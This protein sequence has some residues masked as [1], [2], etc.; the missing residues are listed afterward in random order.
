MFLLNKLKIMYSVYLLFWNER[1]IYL[2]KEWTHRQCFNEDF[3]L[4]S[5]IPKKDTCK[6]SSD[7]GKEELKVIHAL[8]LRKAEAS[9]EGLRN[10]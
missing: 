2:I 7:H 8:H 6:I 9:R 3:N 5:N 10:C 1:E 4:S